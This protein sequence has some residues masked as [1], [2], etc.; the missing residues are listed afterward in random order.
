MKYKILFTL[1][2]SFSLL[3]AESYHAQKIAN[4]TIQ[5]SNGTIKKGGHRNW[6]NNNPGN[7]EYGE[8]AKSNGAI[9]TD[10]RFAI[11]P[12]M[13]VGYKAQMKLLSGD[14]YK[15]K[16]IS[17]AIKKY[18][19]S[20][21]N[22]TGRYINYIAKNLG[23]SKNKKIKH[24]SYSQRL[25]MVKLMAEYEGMKAGYYLKSSSKYANVTYSSPAAA[26]SK[27][28]SYFKNVLNPQRTRLHKILIGAY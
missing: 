10:G 8:F 16:T 4:K 6:R 25:K 17:Q 7:I 3:N 15:H 21:E 23:V 14:A 28:R 19:P 13:N 5:F 18:A 22:N 24:L 12:T 9:G 1:L 11:F 26:I 2:F 20:F 27:S